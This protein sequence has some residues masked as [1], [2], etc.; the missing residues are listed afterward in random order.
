M[1][2]DRLE[3]TFF[4]KKFIFIIVLLQIV[5]IQSLSAMEI[6]SKKHETVEIEKEIYYDPSRSVTFNSHD[7]TVSIPVLVT[8]VTPQKSLKTTLV[9]DAEHWHHAHEL[10][11]DLK[12]K[13]KDS[14]TYLGDFLRWGVKTFFLKSGSNYVIPLTGKL[15]SIS[16]GFR[17]YDFSSQNEYKII[18]DHLKK[19][20]VAA[21]VKD[22][23]ALNKALE[24]KK[25]EKAEVEE[26][27]RK[28]EEVSRRSYDIRRQEIESHYYS[29]GND[30]SQYISLTDRFAILLFC[31]FHKIDAD[32][33]WY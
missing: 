30:R 24:K 3:G 5:C 26:K 11:K 14:H 16:K 12:D 20:L 9:V 28:E 8:R 1:R 7:T 29:Y 32:G 33:A 21:L 2:K 15:A 23:P 17:V 13:N 4:M 25:Q 27:T 18:E 31:L 6:F 19:G 10:F 22:W